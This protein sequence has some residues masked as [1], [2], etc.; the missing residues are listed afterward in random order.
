[1]R[2]QDPLGRVPVH[3]NTTSSLASLTNFEI[4][5][6]AEDVPKQERSVSDVTFEVPE[7][8]EGLNGSKGSLNSSGSLSA[9][10]ITS[11]INNM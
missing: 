7:F 4:E 9:E 3:S 11:Y 5:T 10:E 1:M 2:R 6:L 8:L